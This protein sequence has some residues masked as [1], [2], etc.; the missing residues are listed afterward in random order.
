MTSH[1]RPPGSPCEAPT[2]GG[3]TARPADLQTPRGGGRAAP[4]Q[5]DRRVCRGFVHVPDP[6]PAPLHLDWFPTTGTKL[7]ALEHTCDLCRHV[8][9]EYGLIGGSYRIRRTVRIPGKQ[10]K[11]VETVAVRRSVAAE[12]W[13][14]L[15]AGQA[16]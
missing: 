12:W 11:V 10:T 4:P 1:G 14:L 8:S 7:R 3:T 13:R 9:Y 6:I 5:P 15:L 16:I 2:G